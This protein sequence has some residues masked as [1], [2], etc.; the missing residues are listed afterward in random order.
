[1]SY[2]TR[3]IYFHLQE[4][5]REKVN[6][7]KLEECPANEYQSLLP[8]I[9]WDTKKEI[10]GLSAEEIKNNIFRS[11]CESICKL[12]QIMLNEEFQL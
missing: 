4:S 5:C 9:L 3:A 11:V 7:Q 10:E 12:D 1:M 2:N 6:D 8:T